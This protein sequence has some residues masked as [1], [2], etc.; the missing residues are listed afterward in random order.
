MAGKLQIFRAQDAPSL[1]DSGH[2]SLEPY[3]ELQREGMQRVVAA[4]Y[5]EGAEIA[6]LVDLPGF[7]LIH[8]WMKKGYPLTRHS[9]DSDCLYYIVA[10]SL[11]IGTEELGPR[12]SFFVPAGVAYTYT[13]GPQGVEVLEFRHAGRFNYL[14]LSHNQA[15]YDRAVQACETNLEAW[16]KAVPPSR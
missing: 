15:F 4:G 13:P 2:M 11:T 6:V 16:K 5:L 10:G 12:D 3:T 14:N 9:H 8:A 1:T 7:S